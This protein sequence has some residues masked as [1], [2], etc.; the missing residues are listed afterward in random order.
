MRSVG[1][2]RAGDVGDG[3]GAAIDDR[4]LRRDDVRIHGRRGE[5]PIVSSATGPTQIQRNRDRDGQG[6][7][8]FELRPAALSSWASMGW[9]TTYDR[10]HGRRRCSRHLHDR[11]ADDDRHK[12]R[13]LD[14]VTIN[15]TTSQSAT[16]SWLPLGGWHDVRSTRR[17]AAPQARPTASR[18]RA[19]ERRRS[20]RRQQIGSPRVRAAWHVVLIDAAQARC[21]TSVRTSTPGP[22]RSRLRTRSRRPS[23]SGSTRAAQ[24]RSTAA[25]PRSTATAST[26]DVPKKAA[27]SVFRDVSRA[28]GATRPIDALTVNAGTSGTLVVGIGRRRRGRGDRRHR[29]EREQRDHAQRHDLPRERPVVRRRLRRR[30]SSRSTVGQN[31]NVHLVERHGGVH[32]RAASERARRHRRHRRRRTATSSPTTSGLAAG[33]GCRTSSSTHDTGD[34]QPSARSAQGTRSIR[35]HSPRRPRRSTGTSPPTIRRPTRWG[36]A[37][38]PSS[39]PTSRSTPTRT[40]AG[41]RSAGASPATLDRRQDLSIRS[42]SAGIGGGGRRRNRGRIARPRGSRRPPGRR[43][44]RGPRHRAERHP[45]RGRAREHRGQVTARDSDTVGSFSGASAST[46]RPTRAAATRRTSSST[47]RATRRS[48]NGSAW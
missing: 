46:A 13:V 24:S 44:H 5:R 48:P 29:R 41:S 39:A 1:G 23:R 9:D 2:R 8:R 4:L 43:A 30:I 42:S 22:S 47:T 17:S 45:D 32:R 31:D 18:S 12:Q 28:I 6:D 35:L 20:R 26:D 27:T 33:T 7:G 10:A 19:P 21:R 37:T 16:I 36:S 34:H 15:A 11:R 25:S 14:N 40:T 3:G 38:T